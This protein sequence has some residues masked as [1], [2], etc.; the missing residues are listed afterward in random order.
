MSHGEAGDSPDKE[1]VPAMVSDKREA[2]AADEFHAVASVEDQRLIAA[3]RG[4]DEAAFATLIDRYH[5]TLVRVAALYVPNWA[6]AEE[7]AQETWLGVL[8]GLDRF[9]GRSSLKTWIFRILLN[10]ARRHGAREGRSIPFAAIGYQ[11][12]ERDEPAVDP[13]RFLPPGDRWAGHWSAPPTDWGA[14]P[15]ERLLAGEGRAYVQDAIA[16]LPPT[17]REVITLRDV[18]GWSAE[19]VCNALALSDTNQR[20]LLHRARSKVRSALERY[21]SPIS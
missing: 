18:E 7:V 8:R 1:G 13:A 16:T 14:A 20:V 9:E 12:T 17:Q 5:T 19:E 21:L 4:G 15:E 10:Q 2:V 11:E 3:L 6:V